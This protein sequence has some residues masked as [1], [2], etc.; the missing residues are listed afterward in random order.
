MV[1]LHLVRHGR[2]AAGWD[3]DRDPGLDALGAAQA[4]SVAEVLA[5]DLA[6]RPIISSPLCRARETAV[7][8][9]EA[10]GSTVQIDAAFGEIPSPSVDLAE[11]GR[12]LD[13]TL[14]STW[15][16]AGA[17]VA[18]WRSALVGAALALDQDVV[19]FTHFVAINALVAAAT[20]DPQ[21]TVFLPANAS[22]TELEVDAGPGQLR[23]V[24]RGDEARTDVG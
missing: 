24:R 13:R 12:W 20:D 7:P 17:D 11:R 4:Q 14:R 15:S 6:P 2:A 3:A 10:W 5:A 1:R 16:E 18:A 8:L 9:T 22:V 21:V 19:V 23:V